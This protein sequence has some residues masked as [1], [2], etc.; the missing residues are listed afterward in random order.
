M[1]LLAT[2]CEREGVYSPKK[3]ISKIYVDD[4]SGR[5]LDQ[6]WTWKGRQLQSISYRSGTS[7][8]RFQYNGKQL[9]SITQ[10]GDNM[11]YLFHYNKNGQRLDSL[12]VYVDK[13]NQNPNVRHYAHYD[14]SY[15][16][17]GLI[18]GYEEVIY[19]IGQSKEDEQALAMVLQCAV[20]GLPEVAAT[21]L[22]KTSTSPNKSDEWIRYSASFSYNGENVT[23]CLISMKD[24]YEYSYTFTYTDYLNPYYKFFQTASFGSSNLYSRNLVKT[25]HYEKHLTSEP[26]IDHYEDMEYQYETEDQYPVKATMNSYIQYYAFPEYPDSA[27]IIRYYEYE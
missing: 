27:T 22:A 16:D 7:E 10:L 12:D 1:L 21:R 20:P 2:S 24:G 26:T 19:Y 13:L 15:N 11:Y 3:R 5:K 6:T 9:I 25:C 14:F 23:E 18:S 17:E 4:G 8:L